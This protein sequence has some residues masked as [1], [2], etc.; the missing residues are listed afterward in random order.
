MKSYHWSRQYQNY[1]TI[2][3]TLII[4]E[5]SNY[6]G[7]INFGYI[8]LLTCYIAF[9]VLVT[10]ILPVEPC[11]TSCKAVHFLFTENIKGG[12]QGIIV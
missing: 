9:L 10:H 6:I 2:Y 12:K 1:N 4:F 5:E 11:E 8:W 7:W 3:P